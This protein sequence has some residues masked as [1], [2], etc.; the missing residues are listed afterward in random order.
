M[1]DRHVKHTQ[2]TCEH[3]AF[4]YASLTASISQALDM[5]VGRTG[6]KNKQTTGPRGCPAD[7][8]GRP[9]DPRGP[10]DSEDLQ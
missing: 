2:D 9:V 5:F 8:R 3:D 6:Q 4:M 10:P 7:P 1:H